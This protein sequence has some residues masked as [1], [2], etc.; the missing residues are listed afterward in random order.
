MTPK[1]IL[2]SFSETLMRDERILSAKERALLLSLL[3][4]SKSGAGENPATRE[5]VQGVIA[6]AIGETV[7]QR[8]FAVL[9][10]SIVEKIIE[11]GAEDS[12]RWKSTEVLTEP[13]P[14]HVP[15]RT[16]EPRTPGITP[17]EPQTPDGPKRLPEDEPEPPTISPE[18]QPPHAVRRGTPEPQTPHIS[19]GERK[20]P[21]V[22]KRF[23]EQEPQPPTTS[24]AEPQMP[25]KPMRQRAIL[26]ETKVASDG[27][28]TLAERPKFLPAR[29]LVLEEFLAPQEVQELTR[30]TLE[31]EAD[32]TASEVLSPHSENGVVNYEHRRSRVLMDLGRYE[33]VMI[34]R[35]KSVLPQ[36][37]EKLDMK[38]LTIA[39]IE[40]QITASN[41]GDFFRFHS[42]NGSERVASRYLTF[43]YFFHREPKAFEGGKLRIHD[44]R[45]EGETYVSQGSFQT[46]IPQQNQI[47]FFPCEMRHEI[48]P[49]VC[50][51]RLFA[52][53]RFTL[54]GWLRR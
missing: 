38:P 26:S 7:A 28:V 30:F 12:L 52:D 31:H 4:H 22:P 21:A 2:D 29:C 46:I 37:L 53:S 20:A 34:E 33:E 39:D 25:G 16:P 45:L 51:S 24:P 13:Q 11:S 6:S 43:V 54:N 48:T 47:V 17:G 15:R 19:P 36:V 49:V 42:D 5:A 8:A 18:P 1:Q 35:V 32:F 14:P 9:G 10:A 44:S 50:P 40:A 23:P 41:D 27:G 3:H